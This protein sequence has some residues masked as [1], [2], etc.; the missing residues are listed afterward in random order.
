MRLDKQKAHDLRISG[1]SYSEIAKILE[2]SR[3]TL[4][5]WLRDVDL[6]GEAK[7]EM[8]KRTSQPAL[9][10]LTSYTKKQRVV[11]EQSL[12]QN[13]KR[14]RATVGD[15]LT[16]RELSL[17]GASLYWGEG[18]KRLRMMHG[19]EVINHPVSFT[20][21]D[22]V[23][24]KMF[25]RYLREFHKVADSSVR[26]NVRI[27][28]QQNAEKVLSYWRE[29]TGLPATSFLKPS[30]TVGTG[31]AKKRPTERIPWGVIQLRVYDTGLFYRIM[32]S[33]EALGDLV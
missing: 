3:S 17:V 16:S 12:V 2:V 31:G 27:F 10:A 22:P 11:A 9:R 32:G 19:K 5:L 4:S 7:R 6:S 14:G 21:A 23:I 26:V 30:V 20:N 15:F 13:K 33:I 25:M 1:K 18:Y 8:V 29:V 28:P 24:I